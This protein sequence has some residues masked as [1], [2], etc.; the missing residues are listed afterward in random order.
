[1]YLLTLPFQLLD[2]GALLKQT[3]VQLSVLTSI[4]MVSPR[5]MFAAH[6]PPSAHATF[7][8][9]HPYIPFIIHCR[10]SVS[11]PLPFHMLILSICIGLGRSDLLASPGKRHC[12]N[13]SC[14]GRHNV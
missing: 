11:A 12:R 5:F 9:H 2:T 7:E 6:F 4:H 8:H 14:R 3:T 1:M 13:P 10:F